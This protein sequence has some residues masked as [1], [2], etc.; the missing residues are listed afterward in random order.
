MIPFIGL[1]VLVQA[2][3]GRFVAL[4]TVPGHR[5]CSWHVTSMFW[6]GNHDFSGQDPYPLVAVLGHRRV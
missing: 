3:P 2:V 6:S 4:V 5:V 1:M